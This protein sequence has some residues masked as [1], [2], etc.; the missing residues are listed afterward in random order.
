MKNAII[1]QWDNAAENYTLSQEQSGFVEINKKLVCDRFK[2]FNDQ[3][4]LDLGCGY[5]WYTNYLSS[6][7][8]NVIG[9]DGSSKM[10]GIANNKYP[11]C[12][13]DTVDIEKTLP[14]V[15]SYFDIVFSNQVLMDICNFSGVIDE[16]HRILKNGGLFYFS[17]VHPTFYDC[18]WE[19]DENGFRKNKIMSRYLS[20]YSFENEFWGTTTHYHRTISDYLNTAIEKG[21][22]LKKLCE[23][24][25]YDGVTKSKE[26]PLFLFVELL[27][28]S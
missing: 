20:K 23:P 10:I 27:K 8:G 3:T 5:G 21:F 1:Q 14:Y 17:I 16:S 2:K 28:Q 19:L 7:G 15:N 25:S 22:I 26:F 18:H 6:I 24:I 9:C 12:R 4:I 13:F 11:K